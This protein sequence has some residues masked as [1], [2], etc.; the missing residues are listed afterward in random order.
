MT[1]KT[2]KKLFWISLA[3]FLF[4][5][6]SSSAF[7]V[8]ETQQALIF[9]FGRPLSN[10]PLVAGMHFKMP[11]IQDVK[12]FDRRILQTLHTPAKEVIA[13]DRKRLIVNVYAKYRIGN[14]LLFYQTVRDEAGLVSRLDPI[15]EASMRE[16]IGKVTL[17]CLLAECRPK[18]MSMIKHNVTE[19][20]KSF[21]IDIVDVR[22]TRTDLPSANS[23]AVYKRMR[24]EREKEARAIRAEGQ[25]AAQTIRAEADMQSKIMISEA[26]RKAEELMGDGD[27]TAN[28]IYSDNFNKDPQFFI[29][30]RYMD[31]YKETF[32]NSNTVI[33]LT[34]D[35]DYM[36]YLHKPP[37]LAI[38]KKS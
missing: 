35:S 13:V 27:A 12:F 33:V 4:Y 7:I 20:A 26:R 31:S 8:S 1:T 38:L 15:L 3:A 19:S 24:T 5:V 17:I 11:I 36:K 22:I 9:Q 2:S 28:K 25:E 16:Q 32:K 34:P 6:I 29:F 21:G 37:E 30:L 14:P 10:E 18:T 23:E